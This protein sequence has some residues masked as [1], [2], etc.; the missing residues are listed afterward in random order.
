M[1]D[2]CRAIDHFI[3]LGSSSLCDGL[4]NL[5][6]DYSVKILE[7][8]KRVQESAMSIFGFI[9]EIEIGKSPQEQV[10]PLNYSVKK[11][12]ATKFFLLRNIDEEIISL[13]RFCKYNFSGDHVHG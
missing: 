7:I 8:V 4:F 1:T 3:N 9:P 5:G 6:G 11:L 12:Q 2:T 13:L 10:N